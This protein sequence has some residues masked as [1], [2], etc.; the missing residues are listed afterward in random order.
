[1]RLTKLKAQARSLGQAANNADMIA[2][3][4]MKIGGDYRRFLDA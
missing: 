3:G 2:K 4:R 1:M